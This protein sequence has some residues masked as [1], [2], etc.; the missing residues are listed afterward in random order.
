MLEEQFVKCLTDLCVE[1]CRDVGLFGDNKKKVSGTVL[2]NFNGF[3][4]IHELWK[5]S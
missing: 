3:S 5:N 2:D 4:T 1:D